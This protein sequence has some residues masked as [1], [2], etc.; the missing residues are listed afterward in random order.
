MIVQSL[1]LNVKASAARRL[2]ETMTPPAPL[3]SLPRPLHAAV[4][5]AGYRVL[6]WAAARRVLQNRAAKGRFSAALGEYL[7]RWMP[8]ATSSDPAT[9]LELVFTA[10]GNQIHLT[11]G[12]AAFAT[13]PVERALLHLP[14]LRSFWGNELR[15]AHFEALKAVIPPAWLRDP[16]AVPPGAVIHGLGI[17][18]WSDLDRAESHGLTWQKD[19]LTVR[20]IDGTRINVRYVRNDKDQVVPSS[21]EALP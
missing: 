6:R 12:N 1:V 7:S 4:Q 19:V 10:T 20:K 9:P 2:P 15:A 8:A 17:S 11:G 18:A 16:A 5:S 3:D 21:A 13:E 14:A